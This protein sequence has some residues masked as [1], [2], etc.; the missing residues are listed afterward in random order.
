MLQKN[1]FQGLKSN[2]I[3]TFHMLEHLDKMRHEYFLMKRTDF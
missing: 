3:N 1:T 2:L